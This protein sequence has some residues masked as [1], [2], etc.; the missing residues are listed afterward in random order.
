MFEI[1]NLLN[2]Y[3]DFNLKIYSREGNLI[4]EGGN[5]GGFWDC[6]TNTGL[7][8]TGNPVPTGTYYYV[9]NLNDPQYPD[10]FIGFVYVNY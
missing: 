5:D 4:Y 7:L 8:F 2:I 1:S 9:L 10:P 6:I 3:L